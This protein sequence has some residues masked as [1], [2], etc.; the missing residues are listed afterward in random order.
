M[1]LHHVLTQLFILFAL[2]K[3]G[4]R[5]LHDS[6]KKELFSLKRKRET[7]LLAQIRFIAS[8]MQNI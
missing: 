2:E 4:H 3:F 8:F 7:K 1:K 6:V 5:V